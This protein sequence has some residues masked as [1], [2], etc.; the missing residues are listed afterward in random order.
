MLALIGNYRMGRIIPRFILGIA[1]GALARAAFAESIVT[2][3]YQGIT[4]IVRRETSP[5]ALA[6]HVALI[7]LQEKGISIAVTPHSGTRET[8]RQTTPDFVRLQNAQLG[9]NVAF[10]DPVAVPASANPD[11][12]LAG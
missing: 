5:R 2:H 3:P 1:L 12:F 11:V 8:T 4:Y 10:F 7:D 6:M 9:I